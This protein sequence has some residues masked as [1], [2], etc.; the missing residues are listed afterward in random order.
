MSTTIF[1][2]I[3][4]INE[5]GQEYWSARDLM[6]PLGYS[7]W[8]NFENAIDKAK[9]SCESAKQAISDHFRD[10]AKTISIEK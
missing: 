5:C 1:E 8:E 2:Q 10:A 3:K 7:R 9:I 4:K 6:A